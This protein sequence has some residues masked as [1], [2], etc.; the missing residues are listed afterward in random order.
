MVTSFT[1]GCPE[2]RS[3]LTYS[4]SEN[5]DSPYY[6]DQTRMFSNKQWVDPP[7]CPSELANDPSLTTQTI[8]G[9]LPAAK[10]RPTCRSKKH[11]VRHR[12]CH[13]KRR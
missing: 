7:F 1:G 3:I 11:A 13:K 5:P 2:N 6:A 9:S 12:R 8:Q 4:E 10:P